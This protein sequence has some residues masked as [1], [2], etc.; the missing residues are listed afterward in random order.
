MG[1]NL[2]L[3]DDFGA[4][5][6]T[7]MTGD[8]V[9]RRSFHV[10]RFGSARAAIGAQGNLFDSLCGAFEQIVAMALQCFA[11]R[12]D[13]YRFLKLDSPLFELVHDLF[14]FLEGRLERHGGNVWIGGGQGCLTCL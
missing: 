13:C 7:R 6:S 2:K 8:R 14:E 11:A 3:N 12:V 4:T 9:S 10:E 5:K 1:S